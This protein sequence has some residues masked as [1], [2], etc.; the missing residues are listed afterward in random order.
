MSRK[1]STAL[2]LLAICLFAAVSCSPGELPPL[3][4][5]PAELADDFISCLAK[6]DYEGAVDYFDAKMKRAMPVRKLEQIWTEL[7]GQ[8]G[9]YEQQTD[10]REEFVDGYDVVF[11]TAEFRDDSVV[12]RVVFDEN[13]RVAGL[14]FDPVQ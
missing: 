14:W 7:E 13:R 5:E 11:V 2:I 3:E 10:M 9:P 12:I 8:I 6:S 4:G 1:Y